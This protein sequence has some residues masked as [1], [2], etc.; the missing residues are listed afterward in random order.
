MGWQF[1]HGPARPGHPFDG[2]H[3]RTYTQV[4]EWVDAVTGSLPAPDVAALA[5]LLDRL[6]DVSPADPFDL[7][8]VTAAQ[9]VPVLRR[10]VAR[11]PR[12]QRELTA[13]LADAAQRAAAAGQPWHWS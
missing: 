3:S 10:S 5:P 11:M 13:A 2:F 9:L 1:S 4:S 7:H 8:P 6:D 12:R